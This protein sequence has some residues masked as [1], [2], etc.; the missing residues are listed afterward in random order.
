MDSK[1]NNLNNNQ[2]STNT[3]GSNE[4]NINKVI[5]EKNH[6]NNGYQN[7]R[8]N[9]ENLNLVENKLINKTENE[10]Q[11]LIDRCSTRFIAHGRMSKIWST[12]YYTI[13]ILSIIGSAV[14]TADGVGNIFNQN[15]LIIFGLFLTIIS[16]LNTL[17]NPG[18]NYNSHKDTFK[19]Y[20]DIYHQTRRCDNFNKFIELQNLF[21][22][23][24]Q[25]SPDLPFFML[26]KG[27]RTIAMNPY[28]QKEFKD[29]Y[30]YH[31]EQIDFVNVQTFKTV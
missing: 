21:E 26:K 7:S 3:N 9:H 8:K 13:N 31:D 19:K 6:Q 30:Q 28:L 12:I 18:S 2:N 17:L 1:N 22:D 25:N 29:Y 10:W 16:S 20:R 15:V 4:Q 24:E 5:E 14:V 11:M 23:T 27:S